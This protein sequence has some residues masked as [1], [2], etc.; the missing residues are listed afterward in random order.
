MSAAKIGDNVKIH[1][2]G[3]V[4]G[5]VFDS[6]KE[7]DPLQFTVGEHNVIPGL[8]EAVV[9]MAP[10]EEKRVDV[11]PEKAFGPRRDEMVVQI[12]RKEFPPDVQLEVG[13]RINLQNRGATVPAV[14]TDVSDAA[15]TLDANHVLAG[16]TLE[17]NLELVGIL[18]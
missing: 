1:Y 16:K 18:T 2:T 5:Q 6:S 10:G 7:R 8:E 4:D 14:I 9:G 11:P 13:K 15:V 17:F 3:L 12:E